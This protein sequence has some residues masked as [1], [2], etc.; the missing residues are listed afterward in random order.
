MEKVSVLGWQYRG[1][2]WVRGSSDELVGVVQVR[3]ERT[4]TYVEHRHLDVGSRTEQSK[5]RLKWMI[6][7]Q[8]TAYGADT[9]SKDRYLT[10]LNVREYRG[11]VV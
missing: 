3:N 4:S 7:R 9:D 8:T 5:I 11:V 2:D 6:H 1:R 10:V